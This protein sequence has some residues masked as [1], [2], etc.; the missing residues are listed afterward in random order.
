MDAAEQVSEGMDVLEKV[1][2]AFVD[3]QGRPLQVHC[4]SCAAP[5]AVRLHPSGAEQL[6]FNSAANHH[7]WTTVRRYF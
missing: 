2:E 6:L 5:F 1:N 3:A 4:S 7:A